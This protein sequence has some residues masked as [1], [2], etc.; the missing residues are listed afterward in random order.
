MNRVELLTTL[1]LVGQALAKNDLVPIL[2]NFMFDGANVMAYRD[3]LGMTAPCPTKGAFAVSGDTLTGWLQNNQSEDAEFSLDEQN[4][5]VKAGRSTLKLPYHPKEEFLFEEPKLLAKVGIKTSIT[6]EFVKGLEA[7]LLTSSKNLAEGALLGVVL[8][9]GAL[10]SCD[11][12]AMT[13]FRIKGL[14]C[15]RMMMPNLFCEVLIKTIAAIGLGTNG[16]SVLCFDEEW[17]CAHLLEKG[18]KLWGR[19]LPAKDDPLDHE[20]LI[21]DTVQGEPVFV[22]IPEGLNEALSRARVVAD[23]ESARTVFTVEAGRLK[24]LTEAKLGVVRDSLKFADYEEVEADVSA[25]V[26][27]RTI[28]FCTEMAVLGNCTIYRNGKT[29]Y[30]LVSN[31]GQ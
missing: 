11:G 7:C 27:Q 10:Y 25:E 29:L 5:S 18:L 9:K 19:L 12:D 28:P 4:V 20:K 24:L 26:I 23:P 30:Q 3:D 2:Q 1:E 15:P 21:K 8:N 14:E 17:A 31:M 13:R 16:K 22:P 6:E